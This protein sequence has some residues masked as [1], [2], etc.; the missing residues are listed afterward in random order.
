MN[1]ISPVQ[2]SYFRETPIFLDTCADYPE[3][4]WQ[5]DFQSFKDMQGNVVKIAA[6]GHLTTA[7]QEQA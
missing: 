6:V 7:D 1:E 2:A 3:L 5:Q 4:E